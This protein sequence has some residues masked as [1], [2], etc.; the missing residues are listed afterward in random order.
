MPCSSPQPSLLA[1]APQGTSPSLWPPHLPGIA[2][3]PGSTIGYYSARSHTAAGRSS[4]CAAAAATP[5]SSPTCVFVPAC[6]THRGEDSTHRHRPAMIHGNLQA[7]CLSLLHHQGLCMGVCASVKQDIMTR[8]VHCQQGTLHSYV[9]Y[10]IMLSKHV[11]ADSLADLFSLLL[12]SDAF[13][14]KLNRVTYPPMSPT[15]STSSV[16][17]EGRRQQSM[18]T[19]V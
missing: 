4:L 12:G 3:C 19:G 8:A 2:S 5:A 6:C 11:L 16:A 9:R 18:Q 13:S 7:L 14:A 1:C 15:A 10:I 17:E